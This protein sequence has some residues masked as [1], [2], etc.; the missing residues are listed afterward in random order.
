MIKITYLKN[1]T[2]LQELKKLYFE[3]AKKHHSDITG[4]GNDEVMKQINNEYDYLKKILKNDSE[5][6]ENKFKESFASMESF[7]YILDILLKYPKLKLEIIGT[8]VWIS[9]TG[10]FK[11]KDEVLYNTLHCDYSKAQKKFYWYSGIENKQ[12][13]N[14]KGGFL[15]KAIEK[16]G[17]TTLFSE[18]PISLK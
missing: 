1:A 11:I 13:K 12:A 4:T 10:T 18:N 14:Y 17:K 7:K 8:W 3:L 6:K 5:I 16:F 2:N 9:G 15:S